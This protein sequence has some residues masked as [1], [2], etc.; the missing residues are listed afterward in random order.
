M[1][2][3]RALAAVFG[4]SACAPQTPVMP[5]APSRESLPSPSAAGTQTLLI[6]TRG[7]IDPGQ[8]MDYQAQSGDTLEAIAAHFHTTVDDIR[9]NN[10]GVPEKT[11]TLA[12]GLL[13]HVPTYL[14]PFTGTPYQ[15]IPDSEVVAGPDVPKFDG[16]TFVNSH[17]G[18]LKDFTE[19]AF[20]QTL[21]GWGDVQIVARDFSVNPRLLLALLEYRAQALTRNDQSDEV[22]TFPLQNCRLHCVRSRPPALAGGGILKRGLLRLED[23]HAGGNRLGRRAGDPAG[24]LAERRH[25]RRAISAGQMVWTGRIRPGR[26]SGRVYSNL[27]KPVWRS[28]FLCGPIDPGRF[29]ATENAIAV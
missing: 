14:A 12:P 15:M 6:P 26:R 17:P 13:L 11:T 20:D 8:L 28:V 1:G 24:S 23:G 29:A 18:Y 9:A 4:L 22:K 2:R 21:T 19:Y 25:G 27:P 3:R 10:P 16:K 7:R 5:L